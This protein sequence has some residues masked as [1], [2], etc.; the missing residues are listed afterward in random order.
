MA[1]RGRQTN[2]TT[3]T[4]SDQTGNGAWSLVIKNLSIDCLKGPLGTISGKGFIPR[5]DFAAQQPPDFAGRRAPPHAV[6]A[7]GV[8]GL[9]ITVGDGD[10]A[11]KDTTYQHMTQTKGLATQIYYIG[12][13]DGFYLHNSPWRL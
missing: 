4:T 11:A 2:S 3:A 8:D 12:L 13:N 1:L 9:S 7:V 10:G 5:G 6:A